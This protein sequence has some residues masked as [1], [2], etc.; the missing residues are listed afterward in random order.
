LKSNKHFPRKKPSAGGKKPLPDNQLEP[1]IPP[2]RLWL[3]R[4]CAAILIPLF[5]IGSLEIGLRLC[6]YGYPTSFFLRTKIDGQDYYVPN[7]Q[8]GY[9][10]FPHALARTPATQRMAVKKSPN[11]YRIFVFGESAAMGDPDPSF[12]AWRYLQTLLRERYPGTDFEVICVAMT[13]INSNVLLPIAREC[14]GR[15]GDLWVIYMG[16]NEMVGPFGGGTVF[17]SRAPGTGLIR[18]DIALKATKIG[19][20][21]DQM[22]QRSGAYSSAPKSWQGLDMFQKQ[23]LQFDDPNRLRAYDNFEKNLADIL[24]AGSQAGVPVILSTVGSNLKDCAPFASLHPAALSGISKEKWD[25]LYQNGIALESAG[26]YDGALSQFTQA[27]ALDPHYAELQFEMGSCDLALNHPD[28]AAREFELARDDDALAFRADGRINQIIKDA[29]STYTGKGIRLLDAAAILAQNSPEKIPGNELFYE[30]VHL[31]F[32]GNYLLGRAFA[33]QTAELLPAA[34]TNRSRGD[35]ATQELCDERLA[36]SSW[37]RYRVWQEISSRIAVPPYTAQAHHAALVNLCGEKTGEL[38]SRADSETAQTRQLYQQALAQSPADGFLHWN[39]AEFLGSIGDL[40]GATRE[41]ESVCELLPQDPGQLYD[42]GNLLVIQGKIDSA[43]DYYSRALAV[44]S[45]YVDALNGMGLIL[46]NE[47]K[48]NEA[49]ACFRRAL[50]AE[51]DRAETCLNLGFL[52]Q[53]MGDLTQAGIYYQRAARLQPQGPVDYFN[54]GTA[55][56]AL[57][58]HAEAIRDFEAVIQSK[59][60]FWQAHYLLGNEFLS[61]GDTGEASAQFMDTI[62]YRPDFAGAHL[63]LGIV[64]FQQGNFEQALPEFQTVLQLDPGNPSAQKHIESIQAAEARNTSTLS[65]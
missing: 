60:S 9:R 35:W 42:V 33:E 26:N 23:Q 37:D 61:G 6:G 16:N 56:A 59:P 14:A 53:N 3:Y 32:E 27:A 11:T 25:G 58:F 48:T 18:A 54:Q 12:G 20:L 57:G 45:D 41:A 1:G 38:K 22:M 43:A 62:R 52:E 31:N 30:H 7:D 21:L 8:F 40:D 46:Q 19:Q 28:Q 10:F 51:P 49:L 47:Q 17:G 63:C 36:V 50:R 29:A 65:K 5:I 39:F 4:F 34:I 64:L 13:A 55:A 24:R 2:N 44:Q 15:D